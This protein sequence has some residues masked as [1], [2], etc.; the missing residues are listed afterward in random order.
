[1]ESQEET[2]LQSEE[3]VSQAIKTT[4]TTATNDLSGKQ[5]KFNPCQNGGACILIDTHR[6]TCLCKDLFYGIY[7]DSR[8]CWLVFYTP[9]IFLLFTKW[10]WICFVLFE[11]G[12]QKICHKTFMEIIVDHKVADNLNI[13]ASDLFVNR[14]NSQEACQLYQLNATHS[15]FT[16]QYDKCSTIS[17]VKYIWRV[18][19]HVQFFELFYI[20]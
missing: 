7:C 6:F 12:I 9:F 2:Q 17:S 11:V 1:M 16:I 4:Q 13:Q 5:C 10:W 20:S 18:Y 8:K 19:L 14:K 3:D 15:R